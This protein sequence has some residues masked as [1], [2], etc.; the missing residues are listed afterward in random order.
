VL[1]GWLW[2]RP[3]LRRGWTG[4][5]LAAI[6]GTAILVPFLYP[7][8]WLRAHGQL[9]QHELTTIALSLGLSDLIC[10]SGCGSFS[11]PGLAFAVVLLAGAALWPPARPS[12]R[13]YA[14][15]ALIGAAMSLGPYVHLSAMNDLDAAPGFLFPG[16]YWLLQHWAP[17]F[18]GLRVPGRFIVFSHFALAVLA[19]L[20][21]ARLVAARTGLARGLVAAG[22][23]ATA[24]LTLARP[25]PAFAPLPAADDAAEVYRW[26]AS[27]RA[28]GPIVELPLGP[29]DD[30]I[31]Y[32]SRLHR[33]PLVNGYSGFIPFGH[34]HI[35]AALR[36]Y[37]CPPARS[38]PCGTPSRKTPHACGAS[39]G[40][41]TT[42]WV[43]VRSTIELRL[44]VAA[45]ASRRA[46]RASGSSAAGPTRLG[47]VRVTDATLVGAHA[48]SAPP[49][50]H[51]GLLKQ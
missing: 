24:S 3:E 38:A 14:A 8:A 23:L 36:C 21:T 46:S 35:A 37:P 9:R 49:E 15:V 2:R 44:A 42:S 31:M 5:V 6:V 1:I 39:S 16:A 32:H 41:L 40:G 51:G 50:T 34:R 19:G 28:P 13:M 4:F 47:S 17:G 22:A 20:G 30:F 45:I 33:R 10:W 7:Y 27:E 29:Y 12:G 11:G 48:G 43:P 26:L 25:L 18:D